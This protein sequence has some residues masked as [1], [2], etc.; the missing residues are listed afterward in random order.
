MGTRN[1]QN[2]LIFNTDRKPCPTVTDVS[3]SFLKKAAKEA[4]VAIDIE[5]SGLDWRSQRIGLCQIAIPSGEVAL[6]KAKKNSRPEKFLSL[7]G[8]ASIQK[9]FHHAMFDLR[10]LA[11]HWSAKPA[12]ITCTKIASK[13]IDPEQIEGHSLDCLLER[14]L[15]VTIDKAERQS[16][17]LTWDLSDSQLAYASSDVIYLPKLFASLSA[18]LE[19]RGRWDLAQRCFAHI[20]TR[21]E[22]DIKGF[23][24]VYNY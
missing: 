11:Y 18:Q 12:N 22:L 9:I 3:D 4:I 23:R 8:N 13:L 17:W 5:T 14:Y 21:V 15:N 7:L 20:P 6:L 16:D 10:F 24:D 19:K 1:L 2:P